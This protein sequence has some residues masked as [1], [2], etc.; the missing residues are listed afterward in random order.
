MTSLIILTDSVSLNFFLDFI[1][2]LRSPPSQKSVMMYVLFLSVHI[3]WTS[4]RLGL[5]L[6]NAKIS[7]SPANKFLWI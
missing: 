4:S 3:L 5:F 7:I 6:I 2:L 1:I